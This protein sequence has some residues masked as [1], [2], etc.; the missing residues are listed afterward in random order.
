MMEDVDANNKAILD[1]MNWGLDIMKEKG[2][3]DVAPTPTPSP[4]ARTAHQTP[5]VSPALGAR[6]SATS[7]L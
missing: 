6:S 3:E 7:V 1:T 4:A 5:D 2:V